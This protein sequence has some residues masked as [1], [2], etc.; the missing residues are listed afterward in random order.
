[1]IWNAKQ[2]EKN[3]VMD[4]FMK[5]YVLSWYKCYGKYRLICEKGENKKHVTLVFVSD[6][7]EDNVLM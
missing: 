4:D 7:E 5:S 3:N 2:M 1:M 6:M